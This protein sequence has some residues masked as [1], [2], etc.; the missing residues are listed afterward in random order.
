MATEAV[1]P[2]PFSIST[3]SAASAP[4]QASAIQAPILEVRHVSKRFPGVV[5]LDDV[6][7]P[8]LPGEIHAVV[9]ENG[10][11]KS[12][13]MKILAGAYVPD[14][15][16]IIFQG[17]SVHFAHPRQAQH[18]G[19]SIIYQEFNLLP[20]RTVAENIFLGREPTHMGVID[21]AR[22][23]QDTVRVLEEVDAAHL[24]AP[25]AEVKNLSV[26]QQQIVEIAKALS[27]EAKVLIMDE[28]TAALSMTEVAGLTQLIHKLVD[29]GMTILFISHRFTEVFGL[30]RRISVLKDGR[31]VDTVMTADVTPPEVIKM[32]VGRE[33][34]RYFPPR[35]EP[36]DFGEVVL[37]VRHGSNARLRDINI[38]LRKGEILGIAGL[39]G[40]GRTEL[41]RAIFGADPFTSGAMHLNGQP[42]DMR[43]PQ[44]A[45][46]AGMGFVTEDR[47]G[48]GIFPNQPLSDNILSAVRAMDSMLRRLLPLGTKQQPQ[49]ALEVARH[50]DVRAPSLA[51]EVQ[52]LSGG[53]QQK[54][55]LAKWLAST[56][57]VLIFDEP[58]RGID[59]EAKASIHDMVRD[60]A[61]G[62][63][64][65]LMISSEL[66][67]VIGM[68]DRILV[69][70]DGAIVGE[71]EGGATEE[72]IMLVA[73]GH[74]DATPPART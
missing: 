19:I 47:K 13:L 39:Q 24:I 34:N 45:I 41:A 35:G 15:G 72:E 37:S 68:S 64:A 36:D 70:W 55:V 38:D 31:L 62:G 58:T 32:M 43:T 59:V 29:Q 5:A 6:S 22:L 14:S 66:P 46:G 71:L 33:L 8:F 11:G 10:A 2:E 17:R 54:V 21:A 53:N 25:D 40:S 65:V 63:T 48:E 3:P 49:L 28:P 16:E 30:A 51:Q 67:E 57:K 74:A 1:G 20:E 50:V 69:M 26:A 60:L 61:K 44:V 23:K 7:I 42:L 9:G 4:T 12:T 52:Y 27:F 56:C 18:A 73:T